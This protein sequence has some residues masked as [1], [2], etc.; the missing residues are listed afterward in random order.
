VQQASA[1]RKSATKP[2][3]AAGSAGSV[4]DLQSKLKRVRYTEPEYPER[5]LNQKISGAVT[6]EFTVSTSGEPMDVR[7]VAAEPAGTFDRAAMAAV[8]RWRYAPLVID[9]VPQ[10]V[11][12]RTTIRFNLPSQ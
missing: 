11:P 3:A 8:K 7:V 10:E 6:I 4:A 5:A 12:A 2:A 1:S 9:N